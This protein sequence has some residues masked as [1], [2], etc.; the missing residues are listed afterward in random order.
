MNDTRYLPT[1]VDATPPL[2]MSSAQPDVLSVGALVD[3]WIAEQPSAR[4]R[5]EYHAVMEDF[6]AWLARVA[7]DLDCGDHHKLKQVAQ[8]W[9]ER[10]STVRG[11][12]AGQE[13]STATQA[14]RI[15][16]V[17]S[18]YRF[19]LRSGL[20]EWQ[21]DKKTGERSYE[22]IVANPMRLM[23]RAKVQRYAE[24]QPIEPRELMARMRRIDRSTVTGKRDYALLSVALLTGR[25]IA[26][27]AAMARGGLT[28]ARDGR[29]TV[30]WETKGA[31]VM[32]DHLDAKT[33]AVLLGYLRA[34]YATDDL[35]A[36]RVNAPIWL[37]FS[38]ATRTRE[39]REKEGV[40]QPM[41]ASGIRRVCER[42]LDT[43]KAH[44]WRH[45]FTLLMEQSGASLSDIQARLGHASAA[46]TAQYMNALKS[47]DNPYSERIAA[48]LGIE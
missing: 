14:R 16:I 40:R 45:S 19:G 26:E 44:V 4:T 46:T 20:H 9:S 13:P 18:F 37:A 30:R 34:A 25:R 24:A 41:T 33:S 22:E 10:A 47:A 38:R 1:T 15:A 27:L 17:S 6:R 43:S 48:L 23:K 3:L 31:K 29:V 12:R 5:V 21:R 36:L 32:R 7:I 2:D 35:T 39:A 42:W 8:V 28:I 11:K